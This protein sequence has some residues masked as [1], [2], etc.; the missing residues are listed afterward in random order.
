MSALVP[1]L[2]A[3]LEHALRNQDARRVFGYAALSLATLSALLASTTTP[4]W[5]VQIS[6]GVTTLLWLVLLMAFYRGLSTVS[7]CHWGCLISLI[8]NNVTAWYSGGVYS[9]VLGWM[10]VLVLASYFVVGRKAA[11]FWIVVSIA[12]H[13]LQAFGAQWM[14]LGPVV[15]GMSA[16]QA[17]TSLADYSLIFLI[18]VLVM[19]FYQ[20]NDEQAYAELLQRQN[21]LQSKREDLERELSARDRFIASVSH[22]LRTPMNAILG[23]NS[24]LK[25]V[26]T[27]KPGAQMV[28]EHTSQAADHLMTIINDV[29]DYTQFKSGQLQPHVERV[30]LHTVLQNAFGL[31]KPRIASSN[32]RYALEIAHDIPVWV[33]TDKHRLTQILVNLLGNA[34]KF[35]ETGQ[36]VLRVTREGAKQLRFSVQDTGIGIS[37][38]DQERLFHRFSQANPSIQKRFGGSGLGLLISQRLVQLLD[39]EMGFE[40]QAAV[41]SNFW[42]TLPVGT[43]TRAQ[44]QH[45]ALAPRTHTPASTWCFAIVDDH[46]INRLLLRQVLLSHWP[47]ATVHE[48]ED[49]D[50][51]IALVNQHALDL[52]L[53]DM[54]M[55]GMD[56]IDATQAIRATAAGA[57]LAILGLTANIHP[58]DLANFKAAGLDRIM[59]KPFERAQLLETIETMLTSQ[60][61]SAGGS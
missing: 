46:P 19:L 31:F 43:P 20:R 52:V 17:G 9:S 26:V 54:V 42:F 21:A 12:V 55:V 3:R 8:E 4:L 59:L 41:G 51:A 24:Y 57:Q 13:S 50:Q 53:M 38:E 60:P 56:G 28:L 48:A 33:H 32:L 10:G 7:T 39:G 45:T 15:V 22:E 27:D 23:L 14:G 61:R 18:T 30:Q 29:L 16:A 5:I 34:I 35:T 11:V 36:V 37:K 40:S 58:P 1:S 49:G 2:Q 25:T 47:N 44:E 6:S